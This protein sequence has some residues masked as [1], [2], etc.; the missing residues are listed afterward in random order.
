MGRVSVTKLCS[1]GCY[2]LSPL[3]SDISGALISDLSGMMI[4][5][6]QHGLLGIGV[7]EEF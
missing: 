2:F 4:T 3:V 1:I 7:E 5:G 6:N